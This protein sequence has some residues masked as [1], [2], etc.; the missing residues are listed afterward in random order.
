MGCVKKL[1][2]WAFN[3]VSSGLL[4][5]IGCL[6]SS[7][8]YAQGFDPTC[9]SHCY[10]KD[11]IYLWWDNKA[12]KDVNGNLTT[13]VFD[14]CCNFNGCC[15]GLYG[16]TIRVNDSLGFLESTI[17]KQIRENSDVALDNRRSVF[18]G[19][20]KI[21]LEFKNDLGEVVLA[22]EVASGAAEDYKGRKCSKTFKFDVNEAEI[23][24][25]RNYAVDIK[26]EK[27]ELLGTY[28]IRFSEPHECVKN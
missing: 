9:V 23:K 2:K 15:N 17:R 14:G 25:G 4:A 6:C 3:V 1:K 11:K 26:N 19:C 18:S 7:S 22:K 5:L 13:D 10:G 16:I 27:G 8:V 28:A 24:F 21:R 20:D 12:A